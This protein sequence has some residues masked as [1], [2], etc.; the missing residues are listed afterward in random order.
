[1]ISCVQTA[2]KTSDQ[3]SGDPEE[4]ILDAANA[5]HSLTIIQNV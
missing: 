1:M 5:Q 4:G 2:V 3:R